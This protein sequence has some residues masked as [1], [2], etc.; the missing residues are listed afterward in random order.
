MS[1]CSVYLWAAQTDA[2]VCCVSA[3]CLEGGLMRHM[4]PVKT[5]NKDH[6]R[7]TQRP[8]NSRL[9]HSRFPSARVEKKNKTLWLVNRAQH[10]TSKYFNN[11]VFWWV[12]I[13]IYRVTTVF[14]ISIVSFSLCFYHGYE[15]D[16]K[17]FNVPSWQQ[18]KIYLFPQIFIFIHSFCN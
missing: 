9:K 8:I 14:K 2:P 5:A 1:E 3:E 11:N 16:V 15:F 13:N 18:Q 17:T 4:R 7:F 6:D 10:L 12:D